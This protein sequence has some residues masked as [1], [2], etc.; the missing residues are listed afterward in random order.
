MAK[1]MGAEGMQ[2]WGTDINVLQRL[3]QLQPG[4]HVPAL[5]LLATG[6]PD[7]PSAKPK[8]QG[9]LPSRSSSQ[10]P[11]ASPQAGQNDNTGLNT[12]QQS[13]PRATKLDTDQQGT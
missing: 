2:R 12:I 6:Q 13:L 8:S 10:S 5:T 4:A 9:R 11:T 3:W 1:Q 7:L